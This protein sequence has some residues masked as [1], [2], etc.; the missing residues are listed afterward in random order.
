MLPLLLF[1]VVIAVQS[2]AATA[3]RDSRDV[4]RATCAISGRVTEQETGRPVPRAIVKLVAAS[5]RR[6]ATADAQGHYEFTG[7]DPGEYALWATPGELIATQLAQAYRATR[8]MAPF[9]EPP[10]NITLDPGEALTDINIAL[11]RALA[12]EGRISD[13]WDAPMANVE[14][15]VMHADGTSVRTM[16]GD[17]DDRG[18]FRVYGLAPGRYRVCA[19]PQSF[20]PNTSNDRLRFVRTCHLASL[21][22]SSAADV[23]LDTE[24]ATGIDIRVQR[25]ATYSASGSVLDA[26]GAPAEGAF[27]GSMRDDQSM[28]SYGASRGGQFLLSG[29]L[30]GHYVVWASLGGPANPGDTRPLAR[31]RQFGY[32]TLD[33]DGDT[34]GIVLSLSKGVKI[35]GRV[36]FEGGARAPG[37]LRMVV[38]TRVSQ[39]V[40]NFAERPPF[41][42]VDDDLNFT[43][44]GVYRVPLI[45]GMQ[46]LPDRWVIA[47]VAFEGRDITDIATDLGA[48]PKGR[49]EIRLTSRVARPRI[50][51]TDGGKPMTSYAVVLLSTDPPRRNSALGNTDGTPSRDGVLQLDAMLPGEYLAAALTSGEYELLMRDPSRI[52]ALASI[53]RRVRLAEGDDQMLELQLTRLPRARQ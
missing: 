45:V 4:G 12:I 41:S 29:L 24:D 37:Q 13:P 26:V 30:P 27:I 21:S 43:L 38:Q 15:Q 23:I 8:P 17:S 5:H 7:L 25:S 10:S 22:V 48:N 40:M 14:V 35:T 31:E 33:I 18:E 16:P 49:L 52:E 50:R 9:A 3:P 6:E 36:R 47:S 20:P 44:T 46:G 28:D 32:T 2:Q 11:A 19:L 51:V 53:A 42:A 34:S 39:A 1:V